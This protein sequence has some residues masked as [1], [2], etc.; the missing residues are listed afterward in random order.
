MNSQLREFILHQD[1]VQ[2]HYLSME[3][4]LFD[5]WSQSWARHNADSVRRAHHMRERMHAG[6]D[7]VPGS[8][9]YECRVPSAEESER[10]E[11][12][13]AQRPA[14]RGTRR[15]A[16]T[17]AQPGTRS[18]TRRRTGSDKHEIRGSSSE[19]S[20]REEYDEARPTGNGVEVPP[21]ALPRLADKSLRHQAA[22][23]L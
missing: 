8:D 7:A 18:R 19:E 3:H 2:Y 1:S 6:G 11:Y 15:R 23:R 4:A 9:T 5:S 12:E 20:E 22:C 16:I 14:A 10:K 17:D 13:E 21:P